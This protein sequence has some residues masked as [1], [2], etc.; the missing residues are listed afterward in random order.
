MKVQS[1]N[2]LLTSRRQ[3]LKADIY[4]EI[5]MHTFLL[6]MHTEWGCERAHAQAK[7]QGGSSQAIVVLNIEKV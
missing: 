5:H 3:I 1:S 6:L 2:I 4:P 7:Q